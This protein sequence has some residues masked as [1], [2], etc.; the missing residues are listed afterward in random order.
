M[1]RDFPN[2]LNKNKK[3]G[4]KKMKILYSLRDENAER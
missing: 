3:I 1:E 4:G 2:V